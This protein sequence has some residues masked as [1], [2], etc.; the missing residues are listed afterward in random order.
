MAVIACSSLSGLVRFLAVAACLAIAKPVTAN[1]LVPGDQY[2]GRIAYADDV[3]TIVVSGLG[4]ARLEITVRAENGSTVRPRIE[5]W[6]DGMPLQGVQSRVSSKGRKHRVRTEPLQGDGEVEVR[7]SSVGGTLGP[8][9]VTSKE[10]VPKQRSASVWLATGEIED[11][12]FP[13]RSGDVARFVLRSQWKSLSLPVPQLELPGGASLDLA[14]YAATATSPGVV[15]VGPVPLTQDGTYR[16]RVAG[17]A[18]QPTKIR[19]RCDVAQIHGGYLVQTEPAGSATMS[20]SLALED[21]SWLGMDGVFVADE[22]VVKVRQDADRA[23]LARALDCAVAAASPSGWIRMRTHAATASEPRRAVSRTERRAVADLCERAR[24][25]ARVLV[26]QPNLVR[27]RFDVDTNVPNDPLFVEQWDLAK[28]RFVSAWEVEAGDDQRVVAVLDTGIRPEHPDL[29]GRLAF[30]WDFVSDAWNGGDS[31]GVDPDPTDPFISSGTHGTHVAGTI[32]A[33]VNDGVGVSGGVKFGKLMPVRV[34]GAFGGTDF[35]IAEGVRFAARL[36]NVSGHL[37]AKRAE[38]INMSLGGPGD[39]PLLREAIEDAVD[40]GVVVV[41]AAGNAGSAQPMYPAAY[42]NVIAVSSTNAGDALAFYS[43]F[44]D[45]VDVSAPG[46]DSTKDTNGDGFADGIV[47]TV[48]T[49]ADGPSWGMKMGTS[50]ATPHVA[51]AAFLVRCADPG[52]T[53]LEVMAELAAAAKDLGPVGLDAK[54]GHGR[55]DVREAVEIATASTGLPSAPFAAPAR[56]HFGLH[57]TAVEF[58][59]I[60]RAGS[61]PLTVQSVASDVFWLTPPPAGSVTPCELAASVSRL[62]LAPG[63]YV[64]H[65]TLVTNAG[66]L[67][68]PV[69]MTVGTQVS[70]IPVR[71]AHLLAVDVVSNQ[72]A[73]YVTVDEDGAVDAVLAGLPEGTYRIVATTDL[74]FDHI[75]AEGHDY[76]GGYV[77]P[78]TGSDLFVLKDGDV[79]DP[80]ELLLVPGGPYWLA[81]GMNLA[82]P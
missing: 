30:G 1:E 44:G 41:V 38:V 9:R 76:A 28:C 22:I 39:S 25:D 8:Y 43:S 65:L 46:G 16:L 4:S 60:D 80:I 26:A 51:A 49:A 14:S 81:T 33:R 57:A 48:V 27:H 72:V 35:D 62:G 70:P 29:A 3:D 69:E 67:V 17:V 10:R 75:G 68:V 13:A 34:L 37:P 23:A 7:V 19:V 20:A 24:R 2:F 50:M 11:V 77:D 31:T 63:E 52:L 71:E 40:A 78:L 12:E 15:E 64:A 5:L 36:S 55:L 58:A 32:L 6:K 79:A 54:Y 53:P 18:P 47:S 45:H 82:L 56:L 66:T 74:D 73:K 61:A 59:L 21:T 42:P